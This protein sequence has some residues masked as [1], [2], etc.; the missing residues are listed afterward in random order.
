MDGTTLTT[1]A[2]WSAIA[3]VFVASAGLFFTGRQIQLLRE[4]LERSRKADRVKRSFDFIARW[5]NPTF[6]SARGLIATFFRS[7]PSVDQVSDRFK[8]DSD[9][10][11]KLS[12][13][14]NFLEELGIAWNRDK[15]DKDVCFDFFAGVVLGYWDWLDSFVAE[16]RKGMT[17]E[18]SGINRK[19][20]SAIWEQFEKMHRDVKKRV[21]GDPV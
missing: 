18:R 19:V 12:L 8:N 14:V 21:D 17:E 11:C 1:A 5:N 2:K 6:D 15:L 20:P 7:K 3:G 10:R 16:H 9:F 4:Q 13:V